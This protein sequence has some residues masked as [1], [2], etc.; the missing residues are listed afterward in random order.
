MNAFY[1]N[2]LI[3]FGEKH[4]RESNSLCLTPAK[5]SQSCILDSP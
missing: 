3:F 1:A 5:K 4:K 2:K